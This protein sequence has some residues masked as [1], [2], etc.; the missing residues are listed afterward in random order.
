MRRFDDDDYDD[1][2]NYDNYYNNR[3]LFDF[4]ELHIKFKINVTLI[5]LI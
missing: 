5:V 3:N 2:I 4:V 1:D